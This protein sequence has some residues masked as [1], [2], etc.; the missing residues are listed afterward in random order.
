ME[1]ERMT[2]ILQGIKAPSQSINQAVTLSKT[3]AIFS[4][5]GMDPK[6]L[7][8]SFAIFHTTPD[9]NIT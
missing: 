8:R 9:F 2:A 4:T 6:P 1:T 7:L 5:C 3:A